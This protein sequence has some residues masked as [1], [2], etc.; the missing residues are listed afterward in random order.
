MSARKWARQPSQT[1]PSRDAR[2]PDEGS[3]RTVD[4]AEA[5]RLA[6]L[7]VVETSRPIDSDV[8]LIT[9]E[10][11]RALCSQ[12]YRLYELVSIESS[13]SVCLLSIGNGKTHPSSRRPRLSSTRRGRQRPGSRRRHC[14]SRSHTSSR[15]SIA[16]GLEG[17]PQ[18]T[19]WQ[20]HGRE[21]RTL[22]LLLGELVHILGRDA[23]EELDVLVA[24]ELRHLA[25]GR[26]LC[27]LRANG[28][29]GREEGR[30]R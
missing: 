26:R 2:R 9:R 1:E 30:V 8:A 25:L 27:T 18:P 11:G 10:S 20:H 29:V 19:R 17:R 4:E 14:L 12:T 15:V 3:R 13:L 5:A 24:V 22:H 21:G 6:L 7:G 28:R 16:C 23:L